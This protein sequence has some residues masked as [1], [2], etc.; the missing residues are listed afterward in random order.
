MT[1]QRTY[2]VYGDKVVGATITVMG[3]VVFDPP[4]ANI[5][6]RRLQKIARADQTSATIRF[7]FDEP[8]YIGS[9]SVLNTNVQ[10][11]ILNAW[12]LYTDA[13]FSVV[14]ASGFFDKPRSKN[15]TNSPSNMYAICDDGRNLYV[16]SMS[17]TLET[18]TG[19]NL[20][21]GRVFG[22]RTWFSEQ[23]GKFGGLSINIVDN[24]VVT[25]A[26]DSTPYVTERARYREG[27]LELH[28]ITDEEMYVLDGSNT[29]NREA[30]YDIEQ[31]NGSATEV[32]LIP[33]FKADTVDDALIM[34]G[35]VIYGLP[36]WGR[37]EQYEKC[38]G[39]FL[40]RKTIEI[41]ESV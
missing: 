18:G 30:L 12:A 27:A 25:R 5:Q 13:A 16:Q 31:L 29:Y 20:E 19:A 36:K 17:I 28:A 26:L 6:D 39:G 7:E 23:G 9:I 2:L 22:G 10:N 11:N 41:T 24:S 4:I 34:D 37:A 3:G 32:I 14:A 33:L 15:Q 1:T 40:Y 38:N 8:V 35:Q 21:L